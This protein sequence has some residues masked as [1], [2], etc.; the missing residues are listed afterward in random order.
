LEF[1]GAGVLG[2][3]PETGGAQEA[4]ST[5]PVQIIVPFPPGGVADL[6]T[7]PVAANLEKVL[8][9]PVVVANKGP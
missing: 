5:R 3:I 2:L 1:G 6:T 9:Q 4:Y 8:K 7:R